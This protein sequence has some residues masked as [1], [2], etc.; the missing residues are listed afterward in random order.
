MTMGG[1]PKYD[2]AIWFVIFAIKFDYHITSIFRHI[3]NWDTNQIR[4]VNIAQED[5]F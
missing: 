5:A 2:L 3:H 4:R 1:M